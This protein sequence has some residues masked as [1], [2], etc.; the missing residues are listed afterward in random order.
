MKR[1]E[2]TLQQTI[3]RWFAYK[4]P[5]LK[6][7]LCSNLNNS[8][9]ARTGSINK[10]LGV[11]AGRSDLTLYANGTAYFIEVKVPK[12]RQTEVQK[13]WQ[14]TMEAQGYDYFIVYSLND[15]IELINQITNKK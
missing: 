3:V 11:I 8:K 4:Y 9:D 10:S 7:C 5:H 13:E 14:K 1:E 15:F 6:G 2:Q 12:G